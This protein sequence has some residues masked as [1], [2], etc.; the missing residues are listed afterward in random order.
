MRPKGAFIISGKRYDV[1]TST[2][3]AEGHPWTGLEYDKTFRSHFL[4]RTRAG[5]YFVVRQ[6]WE[7]ERAHAEALSVDLS[8]ILY[9]SLEKVVDFQTAF[10]NVGMEE[11]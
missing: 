3:V 9:E 6:G 7:G 8:M 10:P 11:A 5:N 2:L 1:G 4:Y